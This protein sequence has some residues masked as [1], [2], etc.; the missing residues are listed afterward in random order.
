MELGSKMSW[1][2]M[3]E[4]TT[5]PNKSKYDGLKRLSKALVNFTDDRTGKEYGSIGDLN[6]SQVF[7]LDS[8]SGLNTMA[9]QF[10][11]GQSLARTQ[12]QWGTAMTTEMNLINMLCFDTQ[13]HFV[14][15]AHLDRLVDEINGGM[16]IQ[17][18]ALG[19][20]NAPE[21]PKNFT[22]VVLAQKDADKFTWS[23]MA[24][25]VDLKPRNLPFS[26]KLDPSFK[27]L[28]DTWYKRAVKD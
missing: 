4:Q 14:L 25:K 6:Q 18:N 7:V 23:T 28:Y 8:M 10:V 19:R 15:M 3:K 12:P 9:M 11:S 16:I 22:D 26:D 27:L 21:I 2:L 13:C 17:A 1:G 24:A 20:K 5:D